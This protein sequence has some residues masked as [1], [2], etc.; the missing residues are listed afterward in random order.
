MR[1]KEIKMDKSIVGRKIA[2]ES[3][4][5]RSE[6]ISI[7]KEFDESEDLSILEDYSSDDS[8]SADE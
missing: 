6:S 1:K 8:E 7:L 2:M 4:L 5:V 3:E